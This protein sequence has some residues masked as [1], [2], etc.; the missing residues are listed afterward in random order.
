MINEFF[1]L[2]F[3]VMWYL[4]IIVT[5]I[6]A[7]SGLDDF[8]YDIVYWVR[9]WYRK[10]K[11]RKYSKLTYLQLAEKEEQRIAIMV[12]CWNEA[13]VILS[14]LSHNCN[15]I[16]YQN[17]DLFVGV[18]PNDPETIKA[19]SHAKRT[20]PNIQISVSPEPGPSNKAKNLN[21][22]YNN[23]K[24]HEQKNNVQYCMFVFH[25]AEDVIHPLSL[26]LYNYLI[27]RKDM[28]QIPV[29][30]LEMGI[31]HFTHWVYC[32][33]FTENHTKDI[34]VREAIH[35]LVPS[36]GV[37]TAFSVKA[38]ETLI[39]INDGKPFATNSLTEDYETA[40]KL[41][42]RGLKQIFVSETIKCTALR[43]R[44][45]FF[46]TYVSYQKKEY[47]A[48]RAFFPDSYRTAVRQK[49]RWIFGI[50]I[51]QWL[52]SG[53]PGGIATKYTLFHDR[54]SLVTHI[55]NVLGYILLIFWSIYT[56]IT[57]YFPEYPTLQELFNTNRW[58]W[59]LIIIATI[60]MCSRLLQR[61]IACFRLYK[62]I[63]ALLSIPRSVYGN[64]IN[65]H[66]LLRALKTL[67]FEQ[68]LH[69]KG[70]AWDK[71]MHTFP[72]DAA[73]AERPMKLGDF[74]VQEKVV[75]KAHLLELL[76][77]QKQSGVRLG[78]LVVDTGLI[79]RSKLEN[80]LAAQ[81]KMMR[82]TTKQVRILPKKF[83][84]E[85]TEKQYQWLLKNKVLPIAYDP[86]RKLI[87]LAI[88]DLLD[89]SLLH[90]VTDKLEGFEIKFALI[91]D[92]KNA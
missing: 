26:K 73:M 31:S 49:A 7:I 80:I 67:L 9:F 91:K 50:A 6:F 22:I 45:W 88:H 82:I 38:I 61:F 48:T 63:P 89:E 58:V 86:S 17:Y 47:I 30:P 71:T 76:S 14:M 72:G 51:Q 68:S 23:I 25:D 66:A 74:L 28:I 13:D 85:L 43:K 4:L 20:F 60:V 90:L 81:K 2:L 27:P 83:I 78:K 70:A 18:Y 10:I 41:R 21:G 64:I 54:K 32:D 59:Y 92:N 75:T 12:P 55:V 34:I 36:A 5:I 29:F 37:G 19:V 8:F 16:D 42:V 52:L 57:F 39:E 62:F 46:G 79:S 56:F 77:L 69:V 15:S 35:G 11:F 84:P 53:W 44:F 24:L 33:E 65:M 87:D 3:F 1:L 40:L